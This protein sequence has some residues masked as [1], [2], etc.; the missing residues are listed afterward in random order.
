MRLC[1]ALC[2]LAWA[3]SGFGGQPGAV[4]A[5]RVVDEQGPKDPWTKLVGDLDGD[6]RPD[7]IVGGRKGPL[8]W[9]Q[10][11]DWKRHPI[12]G[13]GY[14]TVGGDTGD[15]D[16]DGDVDILMGGLVWFENPGD[17]ARSPS[18]PWC[19]NVIADHSTHDAQLADFDGDGKLDAVTRDQS[20]FGTKRGNRAHVWRQRPAGPW[21]ETVLEC[22]HG[23]GIAAADLDGDGDPDVILGGLWFETVREAGSV[24]WTPHPYGEFRGGASV[25]VGDFNG[26]GRRD[27]VLA[28]S[29]LA[30]QRDRVAWFEAPRDARS[31]GWR[32]HEIAADVERVFHSLAVADMDG[33]GRDDVVFA[34]MHQGED[35]DEVGFFANLDGGRNWRKQVVAAT[36]SHCL[37]A[38]DLDRDGDIDLF[39]ANWSG[40]R[41]PVEVWE[42]RRR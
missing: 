14:D 31:P 21:A 20:D 24:R 40:P 13:G 11:P 27:I 7:L 19:R 34:E 1:A 26:D 6:G 35:P 23:E 25:A 8:V 36:G 22:E 16:G 9:Y 4:F 3:A 33:D 39:G 5:H 29:E 30:G 12:A 37:R 41:Q 2:V 17:L 42:D 32:E 38:A 15:I 18:R 28:P 10:A